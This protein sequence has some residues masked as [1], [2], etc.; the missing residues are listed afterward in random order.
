MYHASSGRNMWSIDL[1]PRIQDHDLVNILREE[2]W[3]CNEQR[4]VGVTMSWYVT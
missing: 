1:V 2:G 3:Q 4:S